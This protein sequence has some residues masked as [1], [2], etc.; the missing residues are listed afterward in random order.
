MYIQVIIIYIILFIRY[1][2]KDAKPDYINATGYF[3]W[4]W[5]L[6]E[7]DGDAEHNFL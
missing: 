7:K 1:I 3:P 2:I 4:Q 6:L 5:L